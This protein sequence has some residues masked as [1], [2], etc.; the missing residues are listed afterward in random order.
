M[1]IMRN[2]NYNANIRVVSDK[3]EA[4]AKFQLALQYYDRAISLWTNMD[5]ATRDDISVKY[6]DAQGYLSV[7]TSTTPIEIGGPQEYHLQ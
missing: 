1:D 4:I 2:V 3:N 5:Q 7:L 6:K